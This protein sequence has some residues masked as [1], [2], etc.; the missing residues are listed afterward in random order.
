MKYEFDESMEVM[1][2]YFNAFPQEGD[3]KK[4]IQ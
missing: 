3:F 1:V 4:S 2:R